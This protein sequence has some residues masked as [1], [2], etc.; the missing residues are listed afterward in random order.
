MLSSKAIIDTLNPDEASDWIKIGKTLKA[1]E[2]LSSVTLDGRSWQVVL[3]E[4]LSELGQELSVGHLNKIRRAYAFLMQAMEHLKLSADHLEKAPIS[5]MEVAEKLFHLD[6]DLGLQAAAD[7]LNKASP[8]TYIEVNDRYT[9]YLSDHPEKMSPRQAAW[10]TRK[11]SSSI[12]DKSLNDP[13]EASAPSPTASIPFRVSAPY[14]GPSKEVNSCVAALLKNTWMEGFEAGCKESR[15]I[16]LD[17][18]ARIEE[19]V[20]QVNYYKQE[21]LLYRADMKLHY[22]AY[23]ECMGDDHEVDWDKYLADEDELAP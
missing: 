8:A 9:K 19:L 11:S 18:D 7:I 3:R 20:K 15:S 21:A 14:E 1:L 4:R 12:V 23:R 2:D 10:R 16:I 5:A 6:K 17:R 13:L 22:R